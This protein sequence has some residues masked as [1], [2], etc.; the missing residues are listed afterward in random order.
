[1]SK[2]HS[3]ISSASKIINTYSPGKPLAIHLRSFFAAD[4]KFGSKDRRMISSLCY[5]YY[6]GGKAFNGNSIED[7]ILSGLF[8]CEQI[9]NELLQQLKP[10]LNEKIDILIARLNGRSIFL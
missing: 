4:K 2:F 9:N 5:Y 3:Y 1:M 6:R 10:E 7:K 8:L